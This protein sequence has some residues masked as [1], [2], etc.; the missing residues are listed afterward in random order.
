[1]N[2]EITTAA[3]RITRTLNSTGDQLRV[4]F[5]ETGQTL[6]EESS[7]TWVTDRPEGTMLH[8]NGRRGSRHGRMT[9]REAQDWIDARN[10]E[11]PHL[12]VA[13]LADARKA[14]IRA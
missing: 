11:D 14:G 1:M 10:D 2:T 3:R 5:D 6:R 12:T 13:G 4:Y 9:E 8:L 7:S